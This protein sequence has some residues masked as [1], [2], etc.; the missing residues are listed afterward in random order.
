[1][2]DT[3]YHIIF[4]TKKTQPSHINNDLNSGSNSETENNE[5]KNTVRIQQPLSARQERQRN[6]H[7]IKVKMLQHK[8][9]NFIPME[10]KELDYLFSLDK[11]ELLEL[12]FIFNVSIRKSNHRS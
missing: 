10:D 1:M 9:K 6:Q 11:E 4:Q 7:L 3:L 5:N 2:L 12:V 8:V